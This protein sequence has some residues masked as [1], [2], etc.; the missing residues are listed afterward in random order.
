M[1]ERYWMATCAECGAQSEPQLA[2]GRSTGQFSK[3]EYLDLL[4]QLGW[5]TRKG[6]NPN[7]QNPNFW[8]AHLV[9]PEHAPG[10]GS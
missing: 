4:N 6:R 7:L 10:G 8:P 9:C 1:I 3:A 5:R 2:G